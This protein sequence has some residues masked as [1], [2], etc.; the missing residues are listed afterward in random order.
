M[1]GSNNHQYGMKGDKNASWVSDKRI[2][3]YG[4]VLVRQLD[5]P[6]RNGDDFVFEHRLVAEKYLLDES[7]SVQINGVKYLSPAFVVHHLNF[8]RTDNDIKNLVVMP[9]G[10][11]TGMHIKLSKSTTYL[12]EYCEKYNLDYNEV[13]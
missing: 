10:E 7:N 12:K 8:D 4:Y 11:H 9:R 13:Y 2:S 3:S 1:S 6:F 5:H